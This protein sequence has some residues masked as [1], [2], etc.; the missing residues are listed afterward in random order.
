MQVF[1]ISIS[2]NTALLLLASMLISTEMI[3]SSTA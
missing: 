1:S 2:G 3:S